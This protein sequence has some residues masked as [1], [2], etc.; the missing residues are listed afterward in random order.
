M[1]QLSVK[2]FINEFKLATTWILS[3][4]LS[5]M[6]LILTVKDDEGMEMI[7]VAPEQMNMSVD[8]LKEFMAEVKEVAE[9][10]EEGSGIFRIIPLREE[11]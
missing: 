8:E 1:N 7:Y 2:D 10:K 9:L 4:N 11:A 3:R 5:D 6:T